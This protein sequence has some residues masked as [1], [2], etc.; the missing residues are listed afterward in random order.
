[1]RFELQ[2]I[3]KGELIELHPRAPEDWDDLFAAA[4][5]NHE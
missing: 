4:Y 5:S 3:L 2:P 1:M